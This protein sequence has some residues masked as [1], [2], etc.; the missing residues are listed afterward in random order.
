MKLEDIQ[1]QINEH[2]TQ[3]SIAVTKL[4]PFDD[5]GGVINKRV[6][7]KKYNAY[8]KVTPFHKSIIRI[9]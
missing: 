5:N 6:F 4:E 1:N 3:L 9:L 7:V 2:R 8:R